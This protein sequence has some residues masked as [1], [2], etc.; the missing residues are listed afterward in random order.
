MK[1][2][3][4]YLFK[5][6]KNVVLG[7]LM[8]LVVDGAQILIPMI[9][10]KAIDRLATGFVGVEDLVFYA[11]VIIMLALV[12]AIFRFFWRWFIIRTGRLIEER[13]RNELYHHILRLPARFFMRVKTG[14]LMAH[15]TNDL[16]AVRMASSLGIVATTD[17]IIISTFSLIAMI[18]ISPLLTLYAMIPM[19]LLS[20]IV[21]RFGK[22]IHRRFEA[23]QRA[24][25]VLTE[26]VREYVSGIRVIKAF[27]QDKG[28]INEFAVINRDFVNTNMKL[29]RVFGLFHPLIMFFA[30]LTTA[31]TLLAGGKDVIL[32]RI[33]IGEFVAFNYYLGMMVWP[34]I[35]IGW[36]TNIVQ[37]GAA[38]MK[39]IKR[40]LN[41]PPE[42]VES[43]LT[44]KIE[45]DIEFSNL[46]FSY[47]GEPVLKNI[48]FTL[49]KGMK[50]GIMGRTGSGK[51]SLVLLIPRIYEPPAGTLFIDG[52]DVLEYS[53]IHLRRSIGYVPQDGFL[54]ST[55]IRENIAFGREDATLE[56]IIKVS[57][58]AGIYEEIMEFPDGF[59]TIVG[60]RGIT[61]SGGQKQRIAIA[62]ALLIDPAI[63]ILD[64]A[65]SQVDAETEALILANLRE[66]MSQRT[67]IVISHRV[68]AVMDS[69][70]ILVLDNGEIV[71]AGTHEELLKLQGIY[72]DFYEMQRFEELIGEGK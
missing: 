14:D 16:D 59:D 71:E 7:I 55:S 23:V 51:S 21:L 10:R 27:S 17:I 40:I 54:F 44:R 28:A 65:L 3:I 52:T 42:I 15:A 34:M 31:I 22:L 43:G 60:E 4:T 25:S 56:E 36:A 9:I 64:D 6:R 30:T 5:Y 69:D 26:T 1:D 12:I 32:N 19:P 37:R 53:L 2:I 66:F 18:S 35:A 20:F 39:R 72:Y 11:L 8:L 57:K 13:I 70:L 47:N 58:L 45:G 50:L 46:S 48:S 38:S 29:V 33:T 62:R 67:S 63:L 24:F 61:L 68:S 49:R 41:E